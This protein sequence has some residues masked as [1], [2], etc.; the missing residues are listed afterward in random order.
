DFKSLLLAL[1]SD[2]IS[3]TFCKME[4]IRDSHA[5]LTAAFY[6]SGARN[7]S[8]SAHLRSVMLPPAFVMARQ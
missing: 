7:P 6:M 1:F 4:I 2:F 3:S 5:K 8:R